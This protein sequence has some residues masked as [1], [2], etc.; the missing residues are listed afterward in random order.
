MRKSWKITKHMQW[1]DRI[2]QVKI[3]LV[4]AAVVI[5]AASLFVSHQ[6]VSDLKQEE[7]TKMDLWAKAM[8]Y[9]NEVVDE[10]G[11]SLALEFIQSNT[12]IPVIVTD[13]SGQVLDSRNIKDTVGVENYAQQMRLSGDTIPI[14]LGE[15]DYLLVCYD[16]STLLKRLTQYPY[17]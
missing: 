11:L 2:R 15:G 3:I 7:R 9:I 13:A 8:K 14:D 16:E 17:W 5:A 1:T 6:L 10:K 12:T 4:V